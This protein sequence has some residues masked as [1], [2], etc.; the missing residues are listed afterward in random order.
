M[1]SSASTGS[2]GS[3]RSSFTATAPAA[4]RLW[5]PAILL[6]VLAC[7]TGDQTPESPAP[8]T[9]PEATAAPP[10]SPPATPTTPPT[11]TT[12]PTPTPDATATTSPPPAADLDITDLIAPVEQEYQ[13]VVGVYALDTGTGAVVTYQDDERFGYASTIKAVAAAAV[14]ARTTPQELAQT[15]TFSAE[16]LVSYSP[17]TETRVEGGMTLREIIDAAIQDSDNT[18]GNLLLEQLG[19]PAGLQD[20]LIAAGDDTTVVS[21]W[22][23]DLNDYSPGDDRDT[24]TAKALVT[25]MEHY[26][27]GDGLDEAAR[28]VLLESMRGV[29]TGDGTIRAGVPEGWE[30][31]NKTGTGGHGTRNDVAVI[32]PQQ[33]GE[34]IVLAVLTRS[35]SP[36]GAPNDALVAEV[37]ELAIEALGRGGD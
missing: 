37:T 20:D 12:T 3:P 29:L 1:T 21:R 25:T 13:A 2:T 11:P 4:R 31:A 23:P 32:W 35:Q 24:T 15:I 7:G 14:L 34:P 5:L 8:T 16:D 9:G 36:D 18:A 26:A 22:E 6:T 19:G 10:T 28:D 33:G 17:V 30:V 27:L